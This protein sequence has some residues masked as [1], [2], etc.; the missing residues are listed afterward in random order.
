MEPN[1]DAIAWY[2]EEA[3]RLLEEQQRQAESLKTRGGQVAGFG[4]AVLALIGGNATTFL[5]AV[6]GP[7]R[8]VAGVT[9]LAALCSL[10]VA[11]AGA[12]W[13]I[14]KPMPPPALAADEITIYASER[15]R[16][17][18][19]LW[20]VHLRSLQSTEKATRQ[21]QE[22][23]DSAAMAIMISFRAFLLGLAFSLVSMNALVLELI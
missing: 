12:V 21:A 13:A 5:G 19:D 14:S 16:V 23:G 6:E 17:E 1:P 9:L 10:A 4:A 18:P 8:M 22:E 15:F 7:A 2:L 3:Q 11:V 20:R